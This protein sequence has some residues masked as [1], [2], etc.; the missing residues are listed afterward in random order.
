M[1][2]TYAPAALAAANAGPVALATSWGA[3][4]ADYR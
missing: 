4:K 2:E 1:A 3:V